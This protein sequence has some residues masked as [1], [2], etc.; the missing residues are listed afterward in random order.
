MAKRTTTVYP[1]IISENVAQNTEY[2]EPSSFTS[3]TYN[4]PSSSEMSEAYTNS[5][6][7]ES[8][9]PVLIWLRVVGFYYDKNIPADNVVRFTLHRIYCWA[10]ALIIISVSLCNLLSLKDV[11]EVNLDMFLTFAGGCSY[12]LQ[13]INVIS[14]MVASH[15]SKALKKMFV[16]FSNLSKFGGP[17]IDP[18][19][20]KKLAAVCCILN[21]IG[22]AFA[23]TLIT[24][25]LVNRSPLALIFPKTQT[26][27]EE[28]I[29]WV[30]ILS[31]FFMGYIVCCWI[32]CSFLELFLGIILYKEFFLFAKSLKR[33]VNSSEEQIIQYFELERKKFLEMIRIV[34]AADRSLFL[35]QAAC[36]GCNV[37]A[38]CLQLY[39]ICYYASKIH[40]SA[41][42]GFLTFGLTVS[43]LDIAVVCT[44]GILITAGV[45]IL[46]KHCFNNYI[47]CLTDGNI[48]VAFRLS[49]RND[50]LVLS[51]Q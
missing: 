34:K 26:V 31:F 48:C 49:Q 11:K 43:V 13:T 22:L 9:R 47:T 30:S 25:M 18:S 4:K 27:A 33:K 37:I 20:L 6:V 46:M 35:H 19:W 16:C 24:W 45:S 2:C 28:N 5:P 50:A 12:L 21:C 17:Y 29:L 41:A 51:S 1:S 36:F 44:S 8:C 39:A 10:I 23:M 7:Y 42:A 40:S 14:F 15:D 38:L 3:H 32:S